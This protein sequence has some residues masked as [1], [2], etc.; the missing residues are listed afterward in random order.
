MTL[1]ELNFLQTSEG[2]FLLDQ[3]KDLSDAELDRLLFK[4]SK[5]KVKYISAVVS[6]IKLRKKAVGKFGNSEKMFFTD[7][8]LEQSTGENIADYIGKRFKGKKKVVDLTCGIGGNLIFLAK[9]ALKAVSVERDE[10]KLECAKINSQMYNVDKKI[11]FILGD[12]GQNIVQDADAFFIDP[13]RE[14]KGKTKTRSI[15]NSEPNIIDILPKIFEVTKEVCVKISPAFDYDEIKLLPEIPEIEVISEDN[16]CKVVLLWFG[17]FKTGD[18]KATCFIED[19]VY[20]YTDKTLKKEIEILDDPLDYL[21][22]PNKAIIKAHLIN[23]VA[24]EFGLKKIN[25]H[26]SFLTSDKLIKNKKELF[27]IFKII[28][29]DKFSIKDIKKKLKEKNIE[30]VNIITKRFPTKPDELYKKIKIKEGGD[31]FLIV[32]VFRDE[33]YHYILATRDVG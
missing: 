4:L 2:E 1:E 16:V 20:V 18:R 5:K 10:V 30:R 3:Y 33:K 15:L 6:L 14:R 28:H 19:K 9:N 23:E 32:T 13:S 24:C 25:S 17:K 8:S 12:A 7:I 26:T 31:W 22:V 11:E 27:R 29:Y 21:Y